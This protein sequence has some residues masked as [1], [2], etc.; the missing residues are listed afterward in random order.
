MANM[1][2]RVFES[3]WS[4]LSARMNNNKKNS[5]NVCLSAFS[6]VVKSTLFIAHLKQPGLTK[7][8]YIL[9]RHN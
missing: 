4:A 6:F 9:E 3:G 1:P 5:R 2:N 7:V 8:L